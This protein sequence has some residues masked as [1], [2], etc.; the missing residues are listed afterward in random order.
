MSDKEVSKNTL[1][2]NSNT[3]KESTDKQ[4]TSSATS[5]PSATKAAALKTPSA[6]AKASS[7]TKSTTTAKGASDNSD[8]KPG[9]KTAILALIV[10][11]ISIC[12]SV[13][14]YVWQQQQTDY[15]FAAISQK[16]QQSIA[17]SQAQLKNSLT[18]EFNRQ[19]KQQLQQQIDAN[20]L[21]QK[22]AKQTQ[23]NNE[24]QIAQLTAQLGKMEQ[25]VSQRDP[26]DWLIHEADYLVRVA[27]RTM[28]L[29]QD[30]K[31]AISLLR[32]ADNRLK[33]LDQPKFLSIR[34][35]INEDIEALALMPELEVQETILTAMA[36][37]KQ[38]A[39]LTLAGVNLSEAIDA[40]KEDFTLSEDI[41][42][43]QSNLAKTW[44]KFLKDFITVRRRT[45]MVEPLMSPEQQQ[46]LKQNLSLKIQLVE[47]A[48]SEHKENI[49][50]QTLLDIQQ[51]LNEFFDMNATVNKNFYNA[52]EQ[53]KTQVIYFDY[54]TDLRSLVAIKRLLQNTTQDNK[55]AT[56]Q[57]KTK[58][59]STVDSKTENTT[60][61]TTRDEA[62]KPP[63]DKPQVEDRRAAEK[64]ATGDEQ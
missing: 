40:P 1:S 14:H 60:N 37:N 53:L 34:A 26:S 38:I 44:D 31:A 54:P 58:V 50:Q 57:A 25:Q 61:N 41:G 23:L 49:Y 17:Q 39:N 2:A 63:M 33:E 15:R 18:A 10:A 43:W 32:D 59:K 62:V 28:W 7:N 8:K 51:W 35:L 29:E 16:N 30:T 11:S 19:L 13:G 6:S 42:D 48:A 52:I 56:S 46:H 27:A 22:S 20:N 47:W 12:G 21:S 4:S 55:Q 64:S 45:G 3:E 5:N 9:K 36:L 24:N